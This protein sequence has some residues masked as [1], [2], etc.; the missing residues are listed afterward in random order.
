M[1]D[2]KYIFLDFD[3]VINTP[4]CFF[5]KVCIEQLNR[6]TDATSALIVLSTSWRDSH[7]FEE[8][9]KILHDA[10]VTGKIFDTV[11]TLSVF[12]NAIELE[13]ARGIE[14]IAWCTYRGVGTNHVVALDDYCDDYMASFTLVCD[15]KAGLT[16]EIADKAIERL[17]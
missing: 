8:L 1:N 4:N 9:R 14:I 5:N 7:T 15:Y 2:V 13:A 12:L 11:R 16:K 6:I 10:G 17:V 3:G